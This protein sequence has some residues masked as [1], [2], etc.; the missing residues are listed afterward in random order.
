MIQ[1]IELCKSKR[2]TIVVLCRL[3]SSIRL[4]FQFVLILVDALKSC[5]EYY[6]QNHPPISF[7]VIDSF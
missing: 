6:N 2:S 7:S 3:T 1:E 4:S 5:I